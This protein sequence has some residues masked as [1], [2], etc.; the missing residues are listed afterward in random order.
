MT[1]WKLSNFSNIVFIN[2]KK[3]L[4]KAMEEDDRK[5]FSK[6]S[7]IGEND[8]KVYS[9]PPRPGSSLSRPSTAGSKSRSANY[10]LSPY[11]APEEMKCATTVIQKH[12]EGD[13]LLRIMGEKES[14]KTIEAT[15]VAESG[16]LI[17]LHKLIERG[18]DLAAVKGM[19]GY[20]LLHYACNRGHATIVAELLRSHVP[21]NVTNTSGETPLHL[22]VYSGNLLIVEQL[23]DMGANINATNEYNE[24][25]LFYAARK[26]FPVVVRLLLQRGADASVQDKYDEI[27]QEHASEAHTIRAFET[28]RIDQDSFMLPFNELLH[29]FKFLSAREVCRSACVSGK[30]HRVSESEEIWSSLGVRRWECAL[31][32]S[33]G[34]E[35]APMTSFRFRR[36]SKD[37]GSSGGGAGRKGKPGSR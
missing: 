31:Q 3:Y 5:V 26:S 25:P 20:S 36:P 12:I 11:E 19:N 14:S 4:M 2:K 13:S 22:A 21:I 30:W 6:W 33:L 35:V 18:V 15:M 27:A 9:L 17:G 37:K 7:D 10:G 29:V 8:E 23:L 28:Q 34:F 32:S 24:T 16:D 1:H